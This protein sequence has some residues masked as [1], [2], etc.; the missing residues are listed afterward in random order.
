MSDT[1]L[2]KAKLTNFH[3][4][5]SNVASGLN[6]AI[7]DGSTVKRPV[8]YY[9][10]NETTSATDP[11]G[12][13]ETISDYSGNRNHGYFYSSTGSVESRS[14]WRDTDTPWGSKLRKGLH[15]YSVRLG[16]MSGTKGSAGW[17]TNWYP[18]TSANSTNQ[19]Y[20]RAY[21][22]TDATRLNVTGT[23]GAVLSGQTAEQVFS[24]AYTVMAWFKP[25]RA[26]FQNVAGSDN[27]MSLFSLRDADSIVYRWRDGKIAWEANNP[28]GASKDVQMR[29]YD[30]DVFKPEKWY[31]IAVSRDIENARPPRIYVNGK[32][33]ELEWSQEWGGSASDMSIPTYTSGTIHEYGW[34]LG[35][36]RSG[37]INSS[38][39]HGGNDQNRPFIGL[40]TQW[41]GWNT[42]LSDRD[43]YAIY[44][45]CLTGFERKSGYLDLIPVRERLTI[46]DNRTGSY[47]TILRS[48][49]QTRRGDYRSFYDDRSTVI[50]KKH[51][52]VFPGEID[53][54]G[55]GF[56]YKNLFGWWRM[57]ELFSRIPGGSTHWNG[58]TILHG[59]KYNNVVQKIATGTTGIATAIVHGK[60]GFP[61]AGTQR[62]SDSG[63]NEITGTLH[64]NASFTRAPHHKIPTSSWGP[65]PTPRS[66]DLKMM[67]PDQLSRWGG[68]TAIFL[69]QTGSTNPAAAGP[70]WVQFT[71]ASPP[72]MRLVKDLDDGARKDEPWTVSMWVNLLDKKGSPGDAGS[73]AKKSFHGLFRI[74]NGS[75]SLARARIV[76]DGVDWNGRWQIKFWTYGCND[77]D[78]DVDTPSV[79]VETNYL[80]EN[81]RRFGPRSQPSGSYTKYDYA[82]SMPLGWHHLTFVY[83]GGKTQTSYRHWRG[84]VRYDV[85]YNMSS[86]IFE[87]RSTIWGGRMQIWL[88]GR[89][90]ITSATLNDVANFKRIREPHQK[91][92]Y[93]KKI[94]F[95]HYHSD[96]SVGSGMT[97]SMSG[98][99]CEVAFINRALKKRGINRIINNGLKAPS[100]NVASFPHMLDQDHQHMDREP[101]SDIR[102]FGSTLPGT[103]DNRITFTKGENLTPYS[104][105]KTIIAT[106]STAVVTPATVAPDLDSPLG[107]KESFSINISP[108]HDM[109]LLKF[110]YSGRALSRANMSTTGSGVGRSLLRALA[111]AQNTTNSQAKDTGYPELDNDYMGS[112]RHGG[113]VGLPGLVSKGGPIE[114]GDYTGF[115]YFNFHEGKWEQVGLYD[116]LTGNRIEYDYAIST[117]KGGYSNG[118]QT[119]HDGNGQGVNQ[120]SMMSASFPQ[121]FKPTAHTRIGVSTSDPD[122]AGYQT[123][124]Y[125]T[126]GRPHMNQLAPYSTVYHATSSQ[127]VNLSKYISQPF[128]LERVRVKLPVTA[129]KAFRGDALSKT[130]QY[131][132][133]VSAGNAGTRY[134]SVGEHAHRQVHCEDNLVFFIYRQTRPKHPHARPPNYAGSGSNTGDPSHTAGSTITSQRI[135]DYRHPITVS[136]SQ[137]YLIC[138]G[139]ACFYNDTRI[140][141]DSFQTT[142][143]SS[144]DFPNSYEPLHAPAWKHNWGVELVTTANSGPQILSGTQN[145]VYTGSII[146]DIVPAIQ[147]PSTHG[148]FAVFNGIGSWTPGVKGTTHIAGGVNSKAG[149][150]TSGIRK[151]YTM[152]P[153]GTSYRSMFPAHTGTSY[154]GKHANSLGEGGQSGFTT[155][156]T[157]A[158]IKDM[159]DNGEN[160]L[161]K[162]PYSYVPDPRT[163]SFVMGARSYN[164]SGTPQFAVH[165]EDDS[166]IV[167]H[168]YLLL[169]GDELIF[170][171]DYLPQLVDFAGQ[172]N[173]LSGSYVNLLSTGSATVTFY[174]SYFKEGKPTSG[175]L[176]QLLT[177]NAVHE[178]VGN[179]PIYDQ[180]MINERHEY[181]GSYIDNL[182]RGR[183]GGVRSLRGGISRNSGNPEDQALVFSGNL[184][185][186]GRIRQSIVGQDRWKSFS[187]WDRYILTGSATR[188]PN[189]ANYETGFR[190]FQTRNGVP[191][192]GDKHARPDRFTRT[193]Q[194]VYSSEPVPGQ[195]IAAGRNFNY[196]NSSTP[197][198]N[199]FSL[200]PF[201]HAGTSQANLGIGSYGA[202]KPMADSLLR[203]VRMT[204]QNERYYDSLM[205]HLG[206]YT[207]SN[208]GAILTGKNNVQNRGIRRPAMAFPGQMAIPHSGSMR[209]G[210]PGGGSYDPAMPAIASGA[211]KIPLSLA[212][213]IG[214][215]PGDGPAKKGW[216]ISYYN[217]P[218]KSNS[219]GNKFIVEPT[220]RACWMRGRAWDSDSLLELWNYS[221]KD[222]YEGSST[223]IKQTGDVGVNVLDF[224][225]GSHTNY[226]EQGDSVTGK[227]LATSARSAINSAVYSGSL[228]FPFEKTR[229][230]SARNQRYALTVFTGTHVGTLSNKY[231]ALPWNKYII[232]PHVIRTLLFRLGT[233]KDSYLQSF[234]RYHDTIRLRTPGNPITAGEYDNYHGGLQTQYIGS[235]RL[236]AN[237]TWRT[238]GNET[239]TGSY[240]A[241]KSSPRNKGAHGFR[242][243]LINTEPMNT[244]AV[245]RHDHYGHFRDM[246]EQRPYTRFFEKI[247]PGGLQRRIFS[248]NGRIKN[249]TVTIG[250]VYIRFRSSVSG[251]RIKAINTYSQNLSH[252]ASSS[253]PFFDAD[254]DGKFRNRPY[255]FDE[256]I[257]DTAVIVDEDV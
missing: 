59:I 120:K 125:V 6:G 148:M 81:G 38:D 201:G 140:G 98:S 164:G 48:G 18:P 143:V 244:S 177:S 24:K 22:N 72:R 179:E 159:L 191:L 13:T 247:Q 232:D 178:V 152:W 238:Y 243:G 257:M 117:R 34:Y 230:R 199:Y 96:Q 183:V 251:R 85:G 202:R 128:L 74:S 112:N 36:E 73:Y 153:G 229:R 129:F 162:I 103:S 182:F 187:R 256:T 147:G 212:I 196:A 241:G 77:E 84:R 39:S 82:H 169:P 156:S 134:A 44:G 193:R 161:A 195:Y 51:L 107:S 211:G 200:D 104:D 175:M 58:R 136:G 123:H 21:R 186:I 158:H 207:K 67:S 49:D 210:T 133:T 216:F 69:P 80:T 11:A 181:S 25:S 100:I 137:R 170:G 165:G 228:A 185:S 86:G 213:S 114:I 254:R 246:L 90:L 180:Y 154:S 138:S 127:V 15:K 91:I 68:R 163:R 10:L 14:S 219:R 47:P 236:F 56:T 205:P 184:R 135:T 245:F 33:C 92:T 220:D 235:V 110:C 88:D 223:A 119:T 5:G 46:A 17:G 174:G 26:L 171:I 194:A 116:P 87:D 83:K 237:G 53:K 31:H 54:I 113:N 206:Q 43:I 30:R 190:F 141:W 197:E 239:T 109:P 89:Q 189:A 222:G 62:L 126:T 198:V 142:T 124:A 106:G 242:Y 221:S 225:T 149:E 8:F 32:R 101:T 108:K 215:E 94:I 240:C 37:F 248:N 172:A 9:P 155:D 151:V 7:F 4:T 41:I 209:V 55:K 40:V 145:G 214:G 60:H 75:G 122:G 20:L 61:G 231:K 99:I 130:A 50:F 252:V 118:A 2:N 167:E 233:Y 253:L 188:K 166:G 102:T 255:P 76:R 204:T 144:S 52:D 95:G 57:Q 28:A 64:G 218:N 93:E 97:G 121:Q 226:I 66:S 12:G 208:K 150:T 168:P 16:A 27:I 227:S 1:R 42:Q 131:I 35:R 139:V 224:S 23:H 173:E 234:H 3:P 249:N 160:L 65:F 71:D 192:W 217:H 250:A 146:M 29:T 63:P 19:P 45:S 176:N 70:S 78:T 111:R 132:G 115:T 203:G 157:M 105:D 79:S